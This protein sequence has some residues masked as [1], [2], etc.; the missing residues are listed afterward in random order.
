MHSL[1]DYVK[2][3]RLLST[4]AGT[5]G[6][7]AIGVVL[8]GGNAILLGRILGPQH[9]GVYA[10]SLAAAS[11][12]GMAASLG[13]PGLLTREVSVSNSKQDW[14]QLGSVVRTSLRWVLNA[15]LVG[16]A[17]VLCLVVS[18]AIS[19]PLGVAGLA[20]LLVVVP[21]AS[22]NLLRASILRGL[23]SVVSA[24]VPDL[25]FRPAVMLLA[26]GTVYLAATPLGSEGAVVLYVGT[27]FLAFVVGA[28]LLVRKMPAEAWRAPRRVSHLQMTREAWPFLALALVGMLRDQT[29]LFLLG[30]LA[31][32][33]AAGIYHAANRLVSLVVA[34]LVAAN[35]PL[36]PQL[37][38][39]YAHGDLAE[40]QRLVTEA[41]RI[42]AGIALAG[43]LFL[44]PLAPWILGLF[45][46]G[47]DSA[48][49]VLRIL[50]V[51]QL[52]SAGLGACGL[53]LA[54]TGHQG[55]ALAGF[56]VAIAVMTAVGFCLIPTM[57]AVG[58]ALA[59]VAGLV[60]WNT[61]LAFVAWK[62]T[63]LI[64]PIR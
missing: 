13:L 41:A 1:Q 45:G 21:V 56:C 44:V 19:V 48:T 12:L 5:L 2:R 18:K 37:A 40:S 16:V 34:G 55:A 22:L 27:V 3:S 54:M 20:A 8:A 57:G 26:I 51:G 4:A 32:A 25:V 58:A 42:G 30:G 15:S 33:E 17:G 10:I 64:S 46:D 49:N 50:I 9:Y 60:T 53:V 59:N 6:L 14:L 29:P 28:W 61:I 47:F 52:V 36:Q 39:A 23:G 35:L 63:G 7:K 11:L 31:D 38:A 43:A 62:R 24:D